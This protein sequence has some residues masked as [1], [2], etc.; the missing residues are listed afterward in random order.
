MN[1]ILC[2]HGF[3]GSPK[4]IDPLVSFLYEETDW[5]IRAP[6]L[7]GHGDQLKLKGIRYTD[8]IRHAEGELVNLMELCDTI[9]ICGFSM[10]GLIGSWLATRYP[11]KKMVLISAAV[12]YINPKNFYFEMKNMISD[13]FK[14]SFRR[15]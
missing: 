4:D 1:G 5:L 11:V 9:Y 8:W 14:Y 6:I 7:P 2:I 3:T 13:G 12:Y 15:N 10:G